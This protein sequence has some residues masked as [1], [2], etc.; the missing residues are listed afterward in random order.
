[1]SLIK[2]SFLLLSLFDDATDTLFKFT[3][4]LLLNL[5]HL[6]L[7]SAHLFLVMLFMLA[8]CLHLTLDLLSDLLVSFDLFCS[9]VP[10]LIDL[11]S[12]LGHALL[13]ILCQIGTELSFFI[14]HGLVL[15]VQ[16]M[17]L[18]EYG[19]AKEFESFPFLDRTLQVFVELLSHL[20]LLLS[21]RVH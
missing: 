13:E 16:V 5:A 10:Q 9:R 6:R 14:K 19:G 7:M 8:I 15:Q 1:L 17:I 18:F 3:L 4:E 20:Q 12:D 21:L 2:L 11:F